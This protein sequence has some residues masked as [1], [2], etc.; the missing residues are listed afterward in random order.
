VFGKAKRQENQYV[1]AV[2]EF[3]DTKKALDAETISLPFEK[4]LYRDM[5]ATSNK[6]VDDLKGLNKFIKSQ[7]KNKGDVRHYWEGLISEGYTL[8][9][10]IYEKKAPSIERLCD[11]S[12]FKLLCR[13]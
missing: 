13:I 3:A 1:I 11:T 6:R 12:K 9:E 8:L 7:N 4:A 5:I 2:K 10:V